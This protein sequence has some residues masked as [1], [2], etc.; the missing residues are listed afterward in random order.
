MLTG[1]LTVLSSVRHRERRI[2]RA[3]RCGGLALNGGD[4]EYLGCE[5]AD[6]VGELEPGDVGG[7]RV[8]GGDSLSRESRKQSVSWLVQARARKHNKEE[9][10]RSPQPCSA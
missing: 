9:N 6:E 2:R 3:A 8:G 1:V 4:A 5:S 7:R 10:A